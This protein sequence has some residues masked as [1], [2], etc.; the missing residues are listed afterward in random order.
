VPA[1]GWC[2][3]RSSNGC[4]R[5]AGR[6]FCPAPRRSCAG[7]AS[8]C[9][10][11]GPPSAS[12]HAECGRRWTREVVDLILRLARENPRGG[13]TAGATEARTPVF[14]CDRPQGDA[15]ASDPACAQAVNAY[16]GSVRS[17][18]RRAHPGGRL[19]HGGD[20]LARMP[21]GPLLYRGRQPP[22]PSWRRLLT[23]HGSMGGTA[24]SK[25]DLA[26]SGWCPRGDAPTAR[27]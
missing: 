15:G 6:S 13:A 25:S 10:A 14:T 7:T 27:P 26:A 22:R 19:L 17:P 1:I 21:L 11:S 18:A 2:W 16:V 8:S 5:S 9:A 4:P 23:P 12:A 3:R 20:G 24:G